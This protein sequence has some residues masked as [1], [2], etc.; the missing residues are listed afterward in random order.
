[1]ADSVDLSVQLG[2]LTLRNPFIVGSGPTAREVDQVKAAEDA[3]WAAAC[4]KLTID[5]VEHR[6]FEYHTGIGFTIF[7]RGAGSELG[8]GGRYRVRNGGDEDGERATGVTLYVEAALA[9]LQAA[10]V[11][12]RVLLPVGTSRDVAGRLRDS[13][14]VTVAALD[15]GV[16]AMAE[17]RRLRCSHVLDGGDPRAVRPA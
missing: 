10:A 13:G 12:R 4:L 6:G 16:D 14:W 7:A 8:S 5:P 9:V 3:G 15:P 17:A 2:P 1:M 11:P